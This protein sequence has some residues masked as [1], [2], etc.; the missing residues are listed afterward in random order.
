MSAP[1]QRASPTGWLGRPLLCVAVPPWPRAHTQQPSIVV[2]VDDFHSIV[3]LTP[4]TRC[5]II[6]VRVS[7]RFF[8]HFWQR[9]CHMACSRRLARAGRMRL[10]KRGSV[11]AGQRSS[12]C[13]ACVAQYNLSY[14]STS[15]RE[16]AASLSPGVP[17]L[18]H[19]SPSFSAPLRPFTLDKSIRGA[20]SS[21]LC[22][23]ALAERLRGFNVPLPTRGCG[24]ADAAVSL[25]GGAVS[26]SLSSARTVIHDSAGGRFLAVSTGCS[27]PPVSLCTCGTLA[28]TP[29]SVAWGASSVGS[30]LSPAVSFCAGMSCPACKCL[31]CTQ[32]SQHG[33]QEPRRGYGWGSPWLCT[34]RLC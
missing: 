3:G 12:Q 11:A 22:M 27:P 2:A 7:I 18:T 6:S 5:S 29:G 26:S 8:N 13:S 23:S 14:L 28:C 4:L 33:E 17:T 16:T 25:P 24:I 34:G 30:T 15:F 1:Q 19:T 10:A 20:E 32:Q 9:S 21:G 31:S